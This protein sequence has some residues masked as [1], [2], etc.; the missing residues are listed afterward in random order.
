MI[1]IIKLILPILIFGLFLNT[2]SFS[3]GQNENPPAPPYQGGENEEIRDINKQI[4]GQRDKIKKMQ[5]QQEVY[6]GLIKQKQGEKASLNNQLAILDNRLAKAKLDIEGATM[7]INQTNLEIK[8]INLEIVDKDQQ[9]SKQKNHLVAILQLMQKQDQ[10]SALDILLLNNSL[11]EF[12]NQAKYLEDING[13]V[14][15][16]L[17][18]L[19]KYKEALDNQQQSLTKKNKELSKLKAQLDDKK[20]SLIDEQSNKTFI[21][22]QTEYSEKEYQKLLKQAKAEQ[23]QAA[24]EIVSL[25]KTVRAKLLK[26]QGKKLEFNDSGFIWPLP[27]NTITASFHDPDYP[28]RYIFE[29]PAV[30]IRAGQGS[31]IRAAASGY[32]ARAKDAGLGYS[33]IMI[34]HGNGLATVYGHVSRIYVVE[35]E[36]VVQGQA[37]GASGGLPGTPGAGRMTTGSHLHFEIRLNGIPVDPMNYL[38]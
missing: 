9:I 31:T 19:K 36:Y 22:D 13:E 17:K 15:K 11:S 1:K 6:N 25:E 34:V 16:S 21:L 28:F 18:A 30:D 8:K 14:G 33:Y 32:V 29:H 26:I 3:Y 27:R 35:D 2:P 12:I 37:I 10:N 5:D 38:P 24:G 7:E 20:V 23:E 4:E